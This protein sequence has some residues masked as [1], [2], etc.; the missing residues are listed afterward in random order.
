MAMPMPMPMTRGV[1]GGVGVDI[2]WRGHACCGGRRLLGQT[3]SLCTNCRTPAPSTQAQ[4][5][6]HSLV[7]PRGRLRSPEGQGVWQGPASRRPDPEEDPEGRTAAGAAGDPPSPPPLTA[8]P[9]SPPPPPPPP[10]Q[11]CALPLRFV[12]HCVLGTVSG[13]LCVTDLVSMSQPNAQ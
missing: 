11:Y 9:P 10:T 5:L 4:R 13:P 7:L 1:G 6:T 12:Q 2:G 3:C 8:L